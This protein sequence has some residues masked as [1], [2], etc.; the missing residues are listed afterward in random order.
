MWD[1]ADWET[2]EE[3][4]KDLHIP[5]AP[6]SP[7][8][9][10]LDTWL[11]H[12]LDTLMAVIRLHTPTSC[13]SPKLK[14]WWTPSLTS[15]RKEY[16]KACRLARK[17]STEAFVSLVRL[18]RQGYFKAIKKAKNSHRTDFLARTTPH[19]I[20]MA[21]RFVAPC[22][23]P[24]FPDL[25]GAN[26]LVEIN[27]ALLNHFFPPT[28]ELTLRGR[29]HRYPSA[30]PLTKEEIKAA[31]AKSSPT[32]APGPDGVPYSVWKKVNAINPCLLLDLLAPLVAF[33]YHPTSLKHAN[34]VVLDK[35]GKPFYDTPAS[36]RIIV[37]PK[38]VSKILERILTVRLT[39]L[40]REA[41]LL[42]PNQCGSLPGLSTS[43]AVATLTHE[44]G[45]LQRP[46]L[47]VSTL[48]LDIK[49]G[50]DNVNAIKL[51]SL[52][53][54]K[55]VPSYMVDWISSFLTGRKCTLV[56]QGAPSTSAPVSVGTP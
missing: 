27:P 37:F 17:H 51:R 43:D 15:L 41:G 18:S 55:N 20:W 23:T 40:A 21:K 6:L 3:P 54:S 33:G 52:L 22:K 34:G 8:S 16:S 39:S 12:S 45:T 19:N 44:V 53:L 28:P 24:R 11:S 31:L 47:K 29:L 1:K 35:P 30:V 5:P 32:S 2:L 14:P 7:S 10:Q 56:F 13:P 36:F 50:F 38:T 9:D 42:H 46:L 26:S 49:A 25:P 48:F 4:I